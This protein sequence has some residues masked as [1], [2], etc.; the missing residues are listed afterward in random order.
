LQEHIDIRFKIKRVEK[1]ADKVFLLLQVTYYIKYKHPTNHGR[2]QA[3]LGK[4]SLHATEYKSAESN[5]LLDSLTVFRHAD[6]IARGE[7]YKRRNDISS[8]ALQLWLRLR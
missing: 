3:V 5:A 2:H 6:R 7:A 8:S 1:A 4:I